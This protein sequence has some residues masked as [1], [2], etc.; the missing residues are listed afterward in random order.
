MGYMGMFCIICEQTRC[1][2]TRTART[3]F[4]SSITQDIFRNFIGKGQIPFEESYSKVLEWLYNISKC[5]FMELDGQG[6]NWY[7]MVA[8]GSRLISKIVNHND[9]AAFMDVCMV[10]PEKLVQS[11]ENDHLNQFIIQANLPNWKNPHMD[12]K[13][14]SLLEA[15]EVVEETS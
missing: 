9:S 7:E 1:V 4:Q 2:Y 15:K 5:E 12:S 13:A 8:L 14:N 10:E 6:N 11:E 3:T